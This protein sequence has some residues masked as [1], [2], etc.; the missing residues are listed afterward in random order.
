MRNWP[1]A[2]TLIV[3]AASFAYGMNNMIAPERYRSLKPPALGYVFVPDD[4]EFID[5]EH[6]LEV[7]FIRFGSEGPASVTAHVSRGLTEQPQDLP[8]E[9]LVYRGEPTRTWFA[10]LPPL[11]DKGSRWFYYITIETTEGRTIEI[12]K[13]MNW[14]ER[15]F[16]GFSKTRQ[17]FWVTYEGNVAR[18]MPMGRMLLVSHIVLIF[19]ALIFMFHILYYVLQIIAVP[20]AGYYVRAYRCMFWA[21]ISFAV[22]AILLGIPITFY[23]F[24]SGFAPWPSRGLTNLGDITDT[25]SMLLVVWWAVLLLTN[26]GHYRSALGGQGNGGPRRAFAWWTIIAL[27]ITVFVFLIPHS[28]FLQSSR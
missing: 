22:G 14:F 12:W 6:R 26:L 21:M 7:Q 28:Q 9:P 27:L 15:L 20:V 16:S 24:G 8:F 17:H 2:V 5:S 4:D 19:S 11:A 25:K 3:A 13:S 1:L 10:V 18:E 23:T